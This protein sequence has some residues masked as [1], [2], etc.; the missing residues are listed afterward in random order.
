MANQES[1]IIHTGSNLGFRATYLLGAI[2]AFKEL[3]EIKAVSSVYETEP[4]GNS[5]QP[6]YLNQ[7]VE[8]LTELSPRE[9]LQELRRIEGSM[10]RIRDEKWGP[11]TIDLD[12]IFYG[13][14][15]IEE[16]TLT[17]PHPHTHERAFVLIPL[18]EICADRIHP[19]LQLPVWELY[20]QCTDLT[21]VYLLDVPL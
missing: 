14:W 21:E 17:I 12:I 9:L 11:R 4:W 20:D 18:L 8:L 1:A 5:D 7:A 19:K 2:E 3:G 13:D 10:G 6:M 15:I 16:D